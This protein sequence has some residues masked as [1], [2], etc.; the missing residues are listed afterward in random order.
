MISVEEKPQNPKSNYTAVGLYFYSAD[1]SQL[2]SAVKPCARGE[3]EITTL[4]NMYLMENKL[5]VMLQGRGF[6]WMDAGT[7]DSLR[8]ATNFVG[9]IEQYQGMTVSTPEEIGYRYRWISVEQ[10]L[11]SEDKYGNSH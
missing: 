3:L 6:T 8:R 7:I 10:L 5:D 4:N 1:V 9:M 11:D 2:A